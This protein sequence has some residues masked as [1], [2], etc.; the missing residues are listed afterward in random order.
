MTLTFKKFSAANKARSESALGFGHNLNGWSTS[1]WFVAML[2]ELGEAANL[3]KKLNRYRD[4]IRGNK[5]SKTV[6]QVE[7]RKELGDLYV[8]LDLTCQ[9]LGFT[10]EEAAV[11]VFDNKSAELGY[12]TR[13]RNPS[14][15]GKATKRRK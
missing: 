6:L 5:E 11:E 14:K 7:L 3:V 15:Q 9:A 2:G 8:Y 4:G 13:L 1:D 10:I 12:P